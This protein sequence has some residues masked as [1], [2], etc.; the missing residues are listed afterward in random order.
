MHGLPQH[1]RPIRLVSASAVAPPSQVEY[2]YYVL[3]FY[4][5]MG[6][7]I[8][9][10][11]PLLGAGGLAVLAAFCVIR[12]RSR[13]RTISTLIFLPLACAISYIAM[14]LVVHGESLLDDN[15][16][17]FVTWILALIIVQTLSLR[18]GFLHRFAIVAFGIGLT[19]IPYMYFQIGGL[20]VERAA[21]ERTVAI[22]NP[23][24]LA[25]WF[26]FLFV[27]FT[28]LGFETKRGVV[29]IAA[30]LV[31]V[32]CLFI[33]GLTVSRGP[34]FA[35]AVA[36]IIAF[37]RVLKRGVLPLLLLGTLSWVVYEAGLFK[38][39]AVLYG[40]R[41]LEETG[42]FVI[43][44]AAIEHFLSAPL[45]G[46][47]VS[48]SEI[49]VSG[50]VYTPHNSFIYFALTS[51]VIPLLLFLAYWIQAARCIFSDAER[52]PSAPFHL[53][54]LIYAFLITLNLDGI[55]MSPWVIVTLSTA[56]ATGASRRVHRIVVRRIRRG[57]QPAL[58]KLA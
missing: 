55:F 49:Y 16:R 1:S 34:L 9:L 47:G 33:V 45:I 48:N 8:G 2:A 53:P 5:I 15:V 52:L 51:G 40:A 29:R 18:P 20:Q 27:Y 30:W 41:G 3:V 37:R 17:G 23:N 4:G 6:S 21:L 7:A 36:T 39:T 19:T 12:L 54:L 25:A 46:V 32:G 43:W 57:K 42:R 35:V 11:V 13:A 24:D 10:S 38:E 28:V 50:G 14:Q 31:A 22:A 58:G 56:I 44:P 26:G